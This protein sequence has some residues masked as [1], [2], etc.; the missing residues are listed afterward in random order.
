M[1]LFQFLASDKS[2]KDVKNNLVEFI[3]I[4]EAIESGIEFDD[5]IMTDTEIDKDEKTMMSFR[6]QEDLNEIEISSNGY[7]STEY[8]KEYSKKKYFSELNWRFSEIRAKELITYLTKEIKEEGEEIEI[9]SIWIDEFEEPIV[10]TVDINS[11]T[12]DD[13][14]FLDTSSGYDKPKCLVIKE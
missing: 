4:N 7:H 5:S 12:V 8:C 13:L 3:S 14:R 9:W 11:L 10:K 1:S 6:N 2:L